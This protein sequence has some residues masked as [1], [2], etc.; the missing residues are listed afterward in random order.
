MGHAYGFGSGFSYGDGLITANIFCLVGA[1]ALGLITAYR[2]RFNKKVT[3]E[4]VKNYMHF[5]SEILSSLA[6]FYYKTIN[7]THK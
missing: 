5:W 6:V 2:N 4:I 3:L 1:Y 7:L